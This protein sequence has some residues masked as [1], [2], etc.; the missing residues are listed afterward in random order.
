MFCCIASTQKDPLAFGIP[1]F[2]GVVVTIPL[3][4]FLS[5]GLLATAW[6]GD[7]IPRR[8]ILGVGSLAM[9][10]LAMPFYSALAAVGPA[11]AMQSGPYAFESE[12]CLAKCSQ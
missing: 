3:A 5:F 2:E 10:V 6:L 8:W 12:Q 1:F 4:A 11:I 9:A 7:R